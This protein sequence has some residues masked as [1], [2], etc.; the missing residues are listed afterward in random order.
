MAIDSASEASSENDSSITD[1]VEVGV[2]TKV[3]GVKVTRHRCRKWSWSR[4]SVGRA[5]E[6]LAARGTSRSL[7]RS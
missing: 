5:N 7:V 4:V 1:C 2:T 3:C 6:S